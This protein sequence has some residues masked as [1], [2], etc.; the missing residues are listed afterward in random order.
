MEQPRRLSLHGTPS[1]WLLPQRWDLPTG[2]E[3][4]C[5]HQVQPDRVALKCS[6]EASPQLLAG[7]LGYGCRAALAGVSQDSSLRSKTTAGM[8]RSCTIC[9]YST[10]SLG[11]EAAWANQY[12]EGKSAENNSA[13]FQW[14][15]RKLQ[16]QASLRMHKFA[17][18]TLAFRISRLC[19]TAPAKSQTSAAKVFQ[20]LCHVPISLNASLLVRV[21]LSLSL[22]G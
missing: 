19:P 22:F 12:C 21:P 15:S 13:L 5:P 7:E 4:K 3:L 10:K 1:H 20:T 17:R 2:P 8:H 18:Q 14:L 11:R 9:N 16:F 6:C